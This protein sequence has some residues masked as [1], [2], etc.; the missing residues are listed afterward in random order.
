MEQPRPAKSFALLKAITLQNVCQFLGQKYC[1]EA[2]VRV[3]ALKYAKTSSVL[4]HDHL[5][6]RQWYKQSREIF[7]SREDT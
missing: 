1:S 2:G 3:L 5:I 4:L 6:V 7:I